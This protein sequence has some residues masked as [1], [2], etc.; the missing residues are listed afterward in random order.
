[1]YMKVKSLTFR[2]RKNFTESQPCHLLPRWGASSGGHSAGPLAPAPCPW[3][4]GCLAL[5]M[6]RRFSQ[7]EAGD[8]A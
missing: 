3:S 4:S 8:G 6:L 1:M 7:C 2:G 5:W